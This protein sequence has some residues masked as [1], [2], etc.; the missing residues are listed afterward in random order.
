MITNNSFIIPWLSSLNFEVTVNNKV[1]FMIFLLI[2]WTSKYLSFFRVICYFFFSQ[3][4]SLLAS[5]NNFP[6]FFIIIHVVFYYFFSE[7]YYYSCRFFII[8]FSGCFIEVPKHSIKSFSQKSFL[9]FI[10][11]HFVLIGWNLVKFNSYVSLSTF[12]F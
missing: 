1:R 10:F 11:T 12:I 2:F 9:K 7:F 3:I 8:F 5:K 6:I 4:Q